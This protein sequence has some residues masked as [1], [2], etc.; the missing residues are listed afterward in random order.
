M[1]SRLHPVIFFNFTGYRV[2][3]TLIQTESLCK[4]Y[5]KVQANYATYSVIAFL[6]YIQVFYFK[7]KIV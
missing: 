5:E 2:A 3:I 1:D 6:K 7:L 4:S